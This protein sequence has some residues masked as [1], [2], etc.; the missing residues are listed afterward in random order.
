MFARIGVMRV[1]T[2]LSRAY[3]DTSRKDQQWG[4]RR[5]GRAGRV[6]EWR[7]TAPGVIWMCG[8]VDGGRRRADEQ[9]EKKRPRVAMRADA[10]DAL[11]ES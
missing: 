5:L 6:R 10:F 7:F 4:R 1:L 2:A 3:F 9:T 8:P 11:C